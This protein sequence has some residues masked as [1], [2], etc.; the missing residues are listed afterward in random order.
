MRFWPASN[1][2]RPLVCFSSR[3]RKAAKLDKQCQAGLRT[4]CI[5]M[6][7][8]PG[9]SQSVQTTT[10]DPER[11][12]LERWW[13]FN[14]DPHL[15]H[16]LNSPPLKTLRTKNPACPTFPPQHHLPLRCFINIIF[17]SP[18]LQRP[19]FCLYNLFPE[20]ISSTAHFFFLCDFLSKCSLKCES[21]LWILS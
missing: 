21:C 17:L 14:W 3:P 6:N 8:C 12:H 16:S 2:S 11:T 13:I 4:S 5:I 9:A 18:K 1:T 20:P 19:F 10:L 15:G 7:T